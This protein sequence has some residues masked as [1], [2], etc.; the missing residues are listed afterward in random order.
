MP[1]VIYVFVKQK[2]GDEMKKTADF[3]QILCRIH[4]QSSNNK[5]LCECIGRIFDHLSV[6]DEKGNDMIINRGCYESIIQT[7]Y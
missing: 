2:V 4:L 3:T 7:I 1:E 5:T 6:L